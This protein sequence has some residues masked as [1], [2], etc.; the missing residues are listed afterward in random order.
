MTGSLAKQLPIYNAVSTAPRKKQEIKDEIT[1]QLTQQSSR[2]EGLDEIFLET[3]AECGDK[4]SPAAAQHV[5]I[6]DFSKEGSEM[7]RHCESWI[8]SI[9]KV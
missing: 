8:D 3:R 2:G 6:T 1:K 4:S 9:H 5:R 7:A